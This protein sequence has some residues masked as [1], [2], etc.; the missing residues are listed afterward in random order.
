MREFAG[1]G[2]QRMGSGAA[3]GHAVV[4]VSG[5][6]DLSTVPAIYGRLD[7]VLHR[8]VRHV[9]LDLAR[10]VT[11]SIAGAQALLTAQRR[12]R[13]RG[14]R[15]ALVYPSSIVLRALHVNALLEEAQPDR[16]PGPR[17]PGGTGP[18][19]LDEVVDHVRDAIFPRRAPGTSS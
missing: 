3:S 1:C 17:A 18:W 5:G 9:T 19:P 6:V 10:V 16:D 11:C 15:L 13:A 14:D 7:R 2:R 4:V 12:A 8:G